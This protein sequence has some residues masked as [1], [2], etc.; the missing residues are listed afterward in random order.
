MGRIVKGV[1]YI[2]TLSISYG[3]ARTKTW[4]LEKSDNCLSPEKY[5]TSQPLHNISK[6]WIVTNRLVGSYLNAGI[7]NK[8]F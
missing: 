7:V 6:Y 4:K 1:N 5:Q 3:I 2:G 8:G